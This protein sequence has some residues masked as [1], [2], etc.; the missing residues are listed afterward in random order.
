MKYK[1]KEI[2]ELLNDSDAFV[3]IS[4]LINKGYTVVSS[5]KDIELNFL[6]IGKSIVLNE[7]KQFPIKDDDN[8]ENIIN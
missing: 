2:V 3:I 1:S 7:L 4:H 5:H 8:N 6:K